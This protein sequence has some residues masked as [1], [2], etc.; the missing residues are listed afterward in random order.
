MVGKIKVI[1][2][3]KTPQPKIKVISPAKTPIQALG[4]VLQPSTI[5]SDYILKEVYPT[6]LQQMNELKWSLK[7]VILKEVCFLYF[8]KETAAK[9]IK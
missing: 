9:A 2:P 1:S 4:K 5:Q 6:L 7:E 8:H 3:A